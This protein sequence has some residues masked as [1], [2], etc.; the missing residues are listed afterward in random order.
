MKGE[1]NKASDEHLSINHLSDGHTYSQSLY[2]LHSSQW[3]GHP[4]STTMSS[5]SAVFSIPTL[6]SSLFGALYLELLL[7]GISHNIIV[8]ISPLMSFC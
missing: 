6:L 4:F 3:S 8:M 2:K 1:L 5:L 7:N